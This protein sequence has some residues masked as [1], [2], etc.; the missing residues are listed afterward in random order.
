MRH[1]SR[2]LTSARAIPAKSVDEIC[3]YGNVDNEH[4]DFDCSCVAVNL[5]NLD[6]DE[7]TGEDYG[8][9]FGPAFYQPQADA[10]SQEQGRVNKAANPE[11]LYLI[12]VRPATLSRARSMYWL[13]GSRPS[14]VIQCSST[15]AASL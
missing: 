3:R 13:P 12:G 1:H 15:V 9:P 8:Q 10:F 5:V 4:R 2:S 7:R 6:G 14:A 11:T